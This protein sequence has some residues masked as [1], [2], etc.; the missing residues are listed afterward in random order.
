MASTLLGR[1]H[2]NNKNPLMSV[3]KYLQGESFKIYVW[4]IGIVAV[5]R[6]L[7]EFVNH[8][9]VKLGHSVVPSADGVP[10]GLDRWTAW[11]GRWYMSIVDKGYFV[12]YGPD[13]ASNIPFFPG[14]PLVTDALSTIFHIN[15][16]VLGLTVNALLTTFCVYF[17]FRTTQILS[18]KLSQ[19]KTVTKTAPFLAVVLFL[20]FPSS[21]FLAAFYAE[22]L[23]I[24]GISGAI[25]FALQNK[26]IA[27][28]VFTAIATGTKSVGVAVLPAILL[29]HYQYQARS[30]WDW[31]LIRK[32]L[33]LY[34]TVSLIGL[35]G[36]LAYML[37]L[38]INFG[39]PL[40]FSSLQKLW[41]R[42]FHADFLVKLWEIYYRNTFVPAYF[43]GTFNY[44]VT[45][46]AMYG[47]IFA[48]AASVVF[49]KKYRL[50]WILP[51]VFIT[52]LLPATTII[53][54]SMNRYIYCFIP[55]FA[56]F[57][58]LLTRQ[59]NILVISSLV[60]ICI[61]MLIYTSSGF[62]LGNHF[63]G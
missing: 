20:S 13:P 52:V 25:Y 29:I 3:K 17:L 4:C 12:D 24:F 18:R 61:A 8:T 9:F 19:N 23:L 39:D 54:Q 41:L 34:S 63:A 43:Q 15:P 62:L 56:V 21:L 37:Y 22:A 28:A 16:V 60:S 42:E 33:I 27:A 7:L 32:N 14:F 58:I 50:Y 51:L 57:A 47:P 31:K 35:S 46:L 38:Y 6:I 44:L 11:D 5:W 59:K 1:Y 49:A 2:M 26:L 55:L 53:L 30:L 45:L 10:F 48:I 40:L 36:L